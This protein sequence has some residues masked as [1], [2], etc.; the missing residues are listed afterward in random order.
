M[1]SPLKGAILISKYILR[2]VRTW[3]A[4][5]FAIS[6][7]VAFFVS[8]VSSSIEIPSWVF[9]S[10]GAV[11]FLIAN[12]ELF[13][14]DQQEN[15]RLQGLIDEMEGPEALL[16]VNVSKSAFIHSAPV[17]IFSRRFEDGLMP[18]G[19]PVEAIASAT[20]E[21]HNLGEEEGELD[22]HLDFEQSN[23]PEIFSVESSTSSEIID[24]PIRIPGRKRIVLAWRIQC[25]MH[26]KNSYRFS[27]GLYKA[28]DYRFVLQYRTLRVGDPT[29]YRSVAV[30]G[31]FDHYRSELIKRWGESGHAELIHSND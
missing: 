5:A 26:E 19:L 29:E 27:E 30:E 8:S 21:I 12:Y 18:D 25:W 10:I 14:E 6:E 1:Q 17:L 24:L 15:Q 2:L 22:W 28:Q 20:L 3:G 23:I 31:G 7:A 11:A 13:R 16:V 4:R 9:L